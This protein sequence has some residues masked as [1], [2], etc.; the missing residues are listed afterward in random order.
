MWS[1]Y[2]A[3]G[4]GILLLPLAACGTGAASVEQSQPPL[5]SN[6]VAFMGDSITAQWGPMLATEPFDTVDLG[7]GGQVTAQMLTRFQHDV[8]DAQPAV[9]VVVIDGGINDFQLDY[10]GAPVTIDNIASMAEMAHAAGI[11][12]IIASVM[13][14]D[15]SYG[16]PVV[17][18]RSQIET[19]NQQLIDLCA[20]HG[21]AYAD[22][23]DVMLLPDG[24][25]DFSLYTD[26]L[27][28]NAAGYAKMWNVLE[29]LLDE[30][31]Q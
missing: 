25:E 21:Y 3:L 1:T 20:A 13:L 26:G 2:K 27:H 6:L 10:S 19:F 4:M 12:V 5:R 18:T 14:A 31:L 23:Y 17:P 8:I 16:N 9:G 28:P 22:Y 29:P 7:V 15:Y 30:A 24:T 11:R